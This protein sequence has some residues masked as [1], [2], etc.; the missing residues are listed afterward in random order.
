MVEVA[1]EEIVL[2]PY[3]GVATAR[4][5]FDDML[6]LRGLLAWKARARGPLFILSPS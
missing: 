5:T 4:G 1:R 6:A 3:I 2:R